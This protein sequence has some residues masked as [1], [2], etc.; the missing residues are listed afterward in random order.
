MMSEDKINIESISYHWMETSEN[1]F[2]TMVHL[3]D[4][5]DYNWSLF[6]GHL[7]IEKLL[8]AAVVRQTKSHAPFMHDLRR[9]AKLTSL[10]FSEEHFRWLDVIT[11]FNLNARYDSYKKDFYQKCTPEF[12]SVWFNRI[13][14]LR[15]WIKLKL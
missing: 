5:R 2:N 14:V 1:D 8:K 11:T 15:E 13:S 3:Y 6:I 9:L 4:S 7:V 10:E 12:T